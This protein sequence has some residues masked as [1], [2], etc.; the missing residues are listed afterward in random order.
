[1]PPPPSLA[2]PSIH[3]DLSVF[4]APGL[5]AKSHAVAAFSSKG[6]EIRAETSQAIVAWKA[7]RAARSFAK[8]SAS[9]SPSSEQLPAGESALDLDGLF[10]GALPTS[11]E[12]LSRAESLGLG[13]ADVAFSISESAST[14]EA[15]AR[16]SALGVLGSREAVLAASSEDE[17]R[18]LLTRLWRK[19]ADSVAPAFP[20]DRSFAIAALKVQRNGATYFIHPVAHGQRGAPRRF[21]VLSLVRQVKAS[22]QALYSEQNLP[23][24]YGYKHGLETLD[25][26]AA[27]GAAAAVVAAAPGYTRATLL[28]REID[29]A[30]APAGALAALAWVLISPASPSAW[31][32]LLAFGAL[33]WR[34]MSSD[35][36]QMRRQRRRRAAAAQAEGLVDIAE[37]YADE[38]RNFFISKP[39]LEVLRGLELPQPLG[40]TADA[41][42]VRS[43]AIADAV[44]ADAAA[45]GAGE[46][47]L[48]VG[49]LH[50]HEVAWRLADGP[51]RAAP[52]SQIS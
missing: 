13:H 14:P 46:I 42:S 26:A 37:Q 9:G 1:M 7:S 30:L 29:R 39:D 27:Q 12:V 17:F 2:V 22:G 6:D 49:H 33:A 41:A 5:I 34:M 51:R 11:G 32:L 25:H 8:D 20:V 47:H 48:V 31:A 15:A 10:D 23:A 28:K 50:A 52:R 40:A 18:F 4:G 44:A 36:R 16:L 19:T 38:A 35:L 45:S 3:L 43:R 24:Y 21:A